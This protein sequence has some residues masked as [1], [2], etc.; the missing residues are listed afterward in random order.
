MLCELNIPDSSRNKQSRFWRA[1]GSIKSGAR[2]RT[3]H[4]VPRP[5]SHNIPQP[6]RPQPIIQHLRR[7]KRKRNL[8]VTPYYP[9][10]WLDTILT[11]ECQT[12]KGSSQA[13]NGNPINTHTGKATRFLNVGALTFRTRFWGR[14]SNSYIK[15]PRG[16]CRTSN[17]KPFGLFFLQ[18]FIQA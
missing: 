12:H 18:E 17:W 11:L 9:P 14:A 10:Q 4:I 15:E 16:I 13:E 3:S 7:S 6:H 5:Y 8:Y 2:F 1:A